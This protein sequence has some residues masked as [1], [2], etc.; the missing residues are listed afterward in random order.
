MS[1]ADTDPLERARAAAAAMR[2][3]REALVAGLL[4]GAVGLDELAVGGSAHDRAAP[5]K[6]VVVAQSVQGVGKVAARRALD[7][8]GVEEA[9]RWGALPA[10][11]VAELLREL[12]AAAVAPR[13]GGP[14]RSTG[15]GASSANEP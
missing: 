4:S 3:D 14:A 8:V 5:V 12:R 1:G 7:T 10:D 11:T 2:G 15:E 6:A 9:T 13:P